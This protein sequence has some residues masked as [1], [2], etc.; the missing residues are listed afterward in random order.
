MQYMYRFCIISGAEKTLLLRK[1]GFENFGQIDVRKNEIIQMKQR[2]K[3]AAQQ[4][5]QWKILYILATK[6]NWNMKGAHYYECHTKEL[7]SEKYKN[8]EK[9]FRKEVQGYWRQNA[10]ILIIPDVFLLFLWK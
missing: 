1:R 7:T 9:T 8:L 10:P 5:C 4:S 6:Q 2:P 3:A